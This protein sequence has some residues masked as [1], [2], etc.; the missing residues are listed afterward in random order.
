MVGFEDLP[1]QTTTD[2]GSLGISQTY[3][4]FTWSGSE[5]G[6]WGLTD[7]SEAS[8]IGLVP[9]PFGNNFAW[10]WGGSQSL[11][12]DF[13]TQYDVISLAAST[14]YNP[15]NNNNSQTLQ[16]FGYDSQGQQ[17]ASTPELLVLGPSFASAN[18]NLWGISRLEIR[19]NSNN[20]WFAIDNITVQQSL[21]S[22]PTVG[23]LGD[24]L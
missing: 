4:G 11:F 2:F 3:Q 5:S 21:V 10:S 8:R 18:L 17:I 13:Q 15:P 9:T 19:S 12:V 22:E 16:F 20:S 24:Y 7:N 1:D 23:A 14:F 6:R